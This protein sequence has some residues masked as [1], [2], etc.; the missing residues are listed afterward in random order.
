MESNPNMAKCASANLADLIVCVSNPDGCPF[1]MDQ[2]CNKVMLEN[3][4][5]PSALAKMSAMSASSPDESASAADP[6]L[7]VSG[8]DCLY[9]GDKVATFLDIK[10]KSAKKIEVF[11]LKMK[12]ETCDLKKLEQDAELAI[13]DQQAIG[14]SGE[15]GGG[16]E[17]LGG[18][19][20]ALVEGMAGER[21]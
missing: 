6:K 18:N 7:T 15:L 11:N 12:I 21:I 4:C 14:P 19:L 3:V 1:V 10:N 20:G 5:S 2:D 16:G 13:E 9:D 8:E 17:E